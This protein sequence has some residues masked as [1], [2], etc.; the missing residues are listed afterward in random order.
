MSLS[1]SG[2]RNLCASRQR[3]PYFLF[4][5]ILYMFVRQRIC[6]RTT[7]G[8]V[9]H[10]SRDLLHVISDERKEPASCRGDTDGR[11]DGRRRQRRRDTIHASSSLISIA[12]RKKKKEKKSDRERG[13]DGAPPGRSFVRSEKSE[14]GRSTCV[15]TH[16]SHAHTH[17]HAAH[18][19]RLA[20]PASKVY[21][22]YLLTYYY[23]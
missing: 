2:V 3:D 15:D 10:L 22:H 11:T 9:G 19:C 17:T 20:R 6:P 1:T 18:I 8:R 4:S 14:E 21:T 23:V 13:G 12:K 16:P 5:F 7:T